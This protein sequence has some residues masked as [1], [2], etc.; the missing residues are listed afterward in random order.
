MSFNI[1]VGD[2][3]PATSVINSDDAKAKS[4]LLGKDEIAVPRFVKSNPKLPVTLTVI[5]SFTA[6]SQNPAA[7]FGYYH[8][9][10]A[11]GVEVS[12]PFPIQKSLQSQTY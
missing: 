11:A 3:D 5:A 10:N 8:A 12:F 1:N 2:D 4:A 9:G 6:T 7:L